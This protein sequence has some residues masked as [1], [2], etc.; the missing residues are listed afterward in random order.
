MKLGSCH[1][2]LSQKT[3]NL[4]EFRQ[5]RISPICVAAPNSGLISDSPL[6]S[7]F[8]ESYSGLIFIL[9]LFFHMAPQAPFALTEGEGKGLG[10]A[11]AAYKSSLNATEKK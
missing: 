7:A 10:A 1:N 6:I 3:I 5:I 11:A 2:F 8:W 9:S 4:N